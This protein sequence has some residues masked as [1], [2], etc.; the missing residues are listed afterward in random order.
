MYVG[1]MV[2]M[3]ATSKLYYTPKHPYTE[4]LLASIPKPD[5]RNRNRPLK[6]PG[7]VPSPAN[8]PS[9]CYFHPRCRYA[10]DIC[11]KERPPLRDIGGEH[12]VACH[13]AEKLQLQGVTKLGEM[14]LVSLPTRQPPASAPIAP[15]T[16]AE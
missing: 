16:A 6:L 12:W 2:E 3:A 11:K 1:Y 15:A 9:G 5:P 7:D 14:P 8:P 10:E 13:F 4:A